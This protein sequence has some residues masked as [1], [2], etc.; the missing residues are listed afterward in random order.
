MKYSSTSTTLFLSAFLAP[1]IQADDGN[2]FTQKGDTY[3]EDGSKTYA[4]TLTETCEEGVQ[5]SLQ[6][7]NIQVTEDRFLNVTTDKA[8]DVF[9]VIEETTSVTFKESASGEVPGDGI[10]FG[11]E[12]PAGNTSYIG[13]KVLFEC[14]DGIMGDCVEGVEADSPIKAC[15]PYT[16]PGHDDEP[17]GT[18]YCTILNGTNGPDVKFEAAASATVNIGALALLPLLA[19]V[20]SFWSFSPL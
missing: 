16:V 15:S 8:D 2:C 11:C 20:G 6:S 4:L 19:A 3:L 13:F 9:D 5:C 12:F 10:E 18:V 17:S 1:L 7:Q 14:V